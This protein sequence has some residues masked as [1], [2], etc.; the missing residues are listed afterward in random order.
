M[1]IIATVMVDSGMLT[2]IH[3][4]RLIYRYRLILKKLA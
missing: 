3:R 2:L 1:I 4:Y